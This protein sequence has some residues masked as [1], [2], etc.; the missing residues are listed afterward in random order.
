MFLECC[1][2]YSALNTLEFLAHYV[3]LQLLNYRLL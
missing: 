3:L 2:S 1:Q